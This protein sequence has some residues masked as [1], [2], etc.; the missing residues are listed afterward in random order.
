[1]LSS[2]SIFSF[3]C[4]YTASLNLFE[5]I[6]YSDPLLLRPCFLLSSYRGTGNKRARY[7]ADTVLQQNFLNFWHNYFFAVNVCFPSDYALPCGLIFLIFCPIYYELKLLFLSFV[8][9][10]NINSKANGI[11][12]NGKHISISLGLLVANGNK[13]I[14]VFE[15]L[16]SF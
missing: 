6:F 1:M 13:Q 14:S 2:V 7:K 3:L 10:N 5:V 11:N 4:S 8:Q 15:E 16:I 9:A 12:P